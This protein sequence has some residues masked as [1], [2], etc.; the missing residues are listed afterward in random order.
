MCGL[1]L[2]TI[3]SI[4]FGGY[5]LLM[6]LSGKVPELELTAF[7]QAM[8][9]A[10]HAHAGV[11]ILLSLICQLLVDATRL[12]GLPHWLVRA[13]VPFAALLISG[14]F[15]LSAMEPGAT[16]PNGWIILIYV[17]AILLALGLITLGIGLIQAW[18]KP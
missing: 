1:T 18:R 10:G 12:K 11:I 16:Q 7:Q 17:G 13:G 3:P 2:I 8:Y 4:Q 15:F 9:R 14:G 5:F 6:V